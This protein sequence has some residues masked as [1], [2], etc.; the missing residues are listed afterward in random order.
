MITNAED[1]CFSGYMVKCFGKLPLFLPLIN[2]VINL[3]FNE[4]PDFLA[5]ECV[6]FTKVFPKSKHGITLIEVSLC[7]FFIDK[8]SLEFS[9]KNYAY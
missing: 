3:A 2:K 5:D 8:A 1:A 4:F 7:P 6:R 9:L